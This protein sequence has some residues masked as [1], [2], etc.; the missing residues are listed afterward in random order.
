MGLD[1]S[2]CVI[3]YRDNS[4]A[5]LPNLVAL[6]DPED[7]AR[8]ANLTW[9][10]ASETRRTTL[11]GTAETDARGIAGL[12]LNRGES[13]NHYCFS[14]QIQLEPE[15]E[16]FLGEHE[17]ECFD[18]PGSFG[19]MYTSVCAGSK[20][21]LFEMTAATTGMSHVLTHSEAIQDAWVRFA[22]AMGAMIAYIDC[23]DLCGMQLFPDSGEV[24]LPDA[25]TL[26][27]ADI[28]SVCIDLA[29]EYI[30][31]VNNIPFPSACPDKEGVR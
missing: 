21:V 10:P 12:R 17:F 3:F 16:A 7:R 25:N 1:Y 13:E 4:G 28:D 24:V 23:E 19:C 14:L 31:R 8:V 26:I 27:Y 15:M 20:Y 6:L 9:S 29:A 2:L 22:R 5:F 30:R 11:I 18:R